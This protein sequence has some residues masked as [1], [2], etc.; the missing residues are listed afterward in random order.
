MTSRRAEVVELGADTVFGGAPQ[1]GV[2]V[3][4]DVFHDLARGRVFAQHGQR[5]ADLVEALLAV[6]EVLA[7]GRG[8]VGEFGAVAGQSEQTIGDLIE[9]GI[10]ESATRGRSSRSWGSIN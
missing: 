5:R 1:D 9:A 2:D 8:Q 10:S 3:G 7:R 6:V 4:V